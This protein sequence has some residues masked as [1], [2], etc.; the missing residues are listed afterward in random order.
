MPSSFS[1]LPER[2]PVLRRDGQSRLVAAA[3]EDR[4]VGERRGVARV[5]LGEAIRKPSRH[6]GGDGEGQRL[7]DGRQGDDEG[8]ADFVL[9]DPPFRALA[10]EDDARPPGI[11]DPRGEP[12]AVPQEQVAAPADVF[13]RVAGDAAARSV[14]FSHAESRPPPAN[15]RRLRRVSLPGAWLAPGFTSARLPGRQATRDSS[16][17]SVARKA[18]IRS[19]RSGHRYWLPRLQRPR[20]C[21]SRRSRP[22]AR[23][24][25]FRSCRQCLKPSS[26]CRC[27]DS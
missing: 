13:D 12:V 3:V 25:E 23:R 27:C 16:R 5:P 22:S 8:K 4:Q 1:D 15:L 17:W 6:L 21:R 10:R 24:A 2:P 19:I 9:A 7:V 18:Q 14:C 20:A 26:R 11:L